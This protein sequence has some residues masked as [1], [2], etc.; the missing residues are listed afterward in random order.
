MN[1][2]ILKKPDFRK[3]VFNIYPKFKERI[4]YNVCPICL[5]KI[6]YDSF[7]DEISRKEYSV[8]GL[9]QECQDKVFSRI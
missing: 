6:T 3:P 8:S 2:N 5:T 4:V 9:C 1:K 7:R